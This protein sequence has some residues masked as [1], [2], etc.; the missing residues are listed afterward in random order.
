MDRISERNNSV[1]GL[2]SKEDSGP[3][4]AAQELAPAA[5]LG[6][7]ITGFLIGWASKVADWA[8]VGRVISGALLVQ[9]R[10]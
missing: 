9:E 3:V 1:G 10:V 5:Y 2:V 6:N 8:F 7:G 4:A